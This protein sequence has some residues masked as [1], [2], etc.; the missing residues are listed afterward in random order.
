MFQAFLFPGK[1]LKINSFL[2]LQ[3]ISQFPLLMLSFSENQAEQR[4]QQDSEL[5]MGHQP[6]QQQQ[7]Q[8]HGVVRFNPEVLSVVVPP[9]S[10]IPISC[11][12]QMDSRG[13]LNPEEKR[14]SGPLGEEKNKFLQRDIVQYLQL[15]EAKK[16]WKNIP[17]SYGKTNRWNLVK[18][19]FHEKDIFFSKEP[20]VNKIQDKEKINI[21]YFC[22]VFSE[23]GLS[24]N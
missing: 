12:N 10:E 4:R 20:R 18:Q 11:I 15:K 16:Y 24:N 6:G 3:P 22:L 19:R 8:Q 7:Q 2:L 21:Y 17:D 14:V 5:D 13:D 9:S 1:F 23:L